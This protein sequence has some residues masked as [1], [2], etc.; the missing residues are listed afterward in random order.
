[1]KTYKGAEWPDY[2]RNLG[3]MLKHILLDSPRIGDLGLESMHTS[4]GKYGAMETN[5]TLK[6]GKGFLEKLFGDKLLVIHDIDAEGYT[7][8]IIIHDISLADEIFAAVK[9][10]GRRES[11]EFKIEYA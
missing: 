8:R 2:I 4:W 5:Y 11:L 7:P 10:L 6:L 9:K 1:M 3:E